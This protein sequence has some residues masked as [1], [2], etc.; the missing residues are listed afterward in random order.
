[1]AGKI[2]RGTMNAGRNRTARRVDRDTPEIAHPEIE[3]P[4]VRQGCIVKIVAIFLEVDAK[5]VVVRPAEMSEKFG[6]DFGNVNPTA[7]F[8]V[9]ETFARCAEI[10]AKKSVGSDRCAVGV[11]R[12]DVGSHGCG[13]FIAGIVS[14]AVQFRRQPSCAQ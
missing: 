6:A 14:N 4:G 13:T 11:E 1:M 10:G 3:R 2:V 8:V 5:I 12:I 7:R 9:A